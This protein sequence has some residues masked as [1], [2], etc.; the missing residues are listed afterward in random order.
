MQSTSVEIS[1]GVKQSGH[2]AENASPSS[3]QAKNEWRYASTQP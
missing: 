2:K 1:L 3:A